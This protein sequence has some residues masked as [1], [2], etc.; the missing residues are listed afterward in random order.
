MEKE[1]KI[2]TTSNQGMEVA[3]QAETIEEAAKILDTD[4]NE[5]DEVGDIIY[6][7]F[8]G[9][10]DCLKNED[11]EKSCNVYLQDDGTIYDASCSPVTI[12]KIHTDEDVSM[13]YYGCPCTYEWDGSNFK[14]Q[15]WERKV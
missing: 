10:D 5:V 6:C 9:D 2:Y 1:I 4:I 14:F 13:V 8:F 15:D 7:A 11:G 3:C 12:D